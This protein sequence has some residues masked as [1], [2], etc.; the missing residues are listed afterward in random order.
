MAAE[1]TLGRP[2]VHWLNLSIKAGLEGSR[3]SYADA[4]VYMK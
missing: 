2:P 1:E 3:R 4:T